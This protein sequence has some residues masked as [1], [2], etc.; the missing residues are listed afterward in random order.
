MK[1]EDIDKDLRAAEQTLAAAD[2][3]YGARNYDKALIL[4]QTAKDLLLISFSPDDARIASCLRRQ[5]DVLYLLKRFEEAARVYEAL[6]KDKPG[7]DEAERIARIAI[8]LKLARSYEQAGQFQL[9]GVAYQTC[10]RDAIE[11]LPSGHTLRTSVIESGE[12]FLKRVLDDPE[13]AAT[14]PQELREEFRRELRDD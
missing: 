1:T 3:A 10:L 14:V 11:S 12:A 4:Y 9:A 13:L 8:S 7:A 6:L 5:A 2:A